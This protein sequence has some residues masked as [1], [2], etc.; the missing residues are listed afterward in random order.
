MGRWRRL[1][2]QITKPDAGHLSLGLAD[3]ERRSERVPLGVKPDYLMRPKRVKTVCITGPVTELDLES[4]VAENL[5]H[6]ANLTGDEVQLGQVANDSH[7]VEQMDV[8]SGR[9]IEVSIG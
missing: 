3:F 9:H 8:G 6:C 2:F 7:G 5:D 1:Q 4:V